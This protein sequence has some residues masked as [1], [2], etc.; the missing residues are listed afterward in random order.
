MDEGRVLTAHCDMLTLYASKME[1]GETVI[2]TVS[3]LK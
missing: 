2:M 1:E 3:Q